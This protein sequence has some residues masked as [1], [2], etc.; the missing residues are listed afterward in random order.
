[1]S[2]FG[3]VFHSQFRFKAD[4]YII[5]PDFLSPGE[6]VD[7]TLKKY[8]RELDGSDCIVVGH[9]RTGEITNTNNK[10]VCSIKPFS[11]GTYGY[12]RLTSNGPE[13]YSN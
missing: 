2:F 9:T 8:V 13:L 5:T 10:D 1:M 7:S 3:I 11:P 6:S 4:T 12:A